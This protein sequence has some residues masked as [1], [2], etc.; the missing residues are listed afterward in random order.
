MRRDESFHRVSLAF[1]RTTFNRLVLEHLPAAQRFAI[2]LTGDVGSAEDLMQDALLKAHR[3]WQTF[4]GESRFQTWLFQIVINEFRRAVRHAASAQL[5]DTSEIEDGRAMQPARS[6]EARELGEL[7]AQEVS[8][9]PPRQ[10]EVLVLI[11]Y[12]QLSVSEVALILNL[13]QQNV[14]TN[15]HYARQTLRHHLKKYLDE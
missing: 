14:R 13:S 5:A 2:R 8:R 11:T 1:D 6:L 10:R 15:L 12:E 4:R 9:L 7:V 3:S